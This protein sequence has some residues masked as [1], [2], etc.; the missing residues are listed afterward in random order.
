MWNRAK[1][2]PC[3]SKHRSK[4]T[5]CGLWVI[6]EPTAMEKV[7]GTPGA[8]LTWRFFF[9]F[10]PRSFPGTFPDSPNTQQL[11]TSRIRV[12]IP[13]LLHSQ[14]AL[15]WVTAH[16]SCSWQV[17]PLVLVALCDIVPPSIN[18]RPHIGQIR[19]KFHQPASAL[20]ALAFNVVK[21]NNFYSNICRLSQNFFSGL[22]LWAP[23]RSQQGPGAKLWLSP[24]SLCAHMVVLGVTLYLPL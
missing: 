11:E 1:G 19:P 10:S 15:S 7:L 3:W 2:K 17:P 16:H 14:A 9:F 4:S 23:P 20:A 22:N 5:P 24:C 8:L 18:V 13:A 12:T 6:P 21:R